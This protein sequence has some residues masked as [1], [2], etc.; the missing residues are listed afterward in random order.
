MSP[1]EKKVKKK[2]DIQR[3]LLIS[4]KTVE[5]NS[6]LTQTTRHSRCES[7]GWSMDSTGVSKNAFAL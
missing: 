7:L 3:Y 4:C 5:F 6:M 1:V 2:L